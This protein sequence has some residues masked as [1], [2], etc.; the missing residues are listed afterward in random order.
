M[1]RMICSSCGTQNPP[2]AKFCTECASRLAIACAACGTANSPT[3]KYCAECAAPLQGAA[4][5][6]LAATRVAAVVQPQTAT[7][8]LR[9]VS[10]LFADLV[11]F[12]ALAEGRDAEETRELLTN[13]FDLSR[14]V[15]GRYGGTIEKFIGDA[16]MAVWGAPIAREDDA[17]RAVR[18]AIDL[19]AAVGALGPSV[20]ARAGVLTGEAATTVGATNQGM[21]A[22]DLVN[23]ASRLQSVAPSGTV[24]VGEAT[25]RAASRAIVFEEAGEHLLK[26]KASPVP[27]WRA[28]RVVAERGGRNRSETL[29][30]PFVGRDDELRLLKD[31]FHAT[32]REG[33]SRL[34]SVIGPA[35]IG[36][37]RLA[38]EFLKYVD[39][40]VESV[41][42]HDGRS[43]AYGEGIAFWALGEMIRGRAKLH[44]SDDEPTTRSGIAAML[45]EHVPDEA[46]RAW[47]EPALLS[48]LGIGSG[49]GSSQQLFGAWRTFFERLAASG[50]V[51]MIFEDLHH[52]DPGL[53]DFIDHLLDWS[54]NLPILMVTLA[55]PELLERRPDWGAGKRSF[56]SIYLEPLPVPAMRR[57][58]AGLVPGLPAAA[59]D[60]IVKRADGIPLYA[61]ETVR[62]LLAQSRLVLEDGVY[63]P[64]D[65]LTDLAVPDT[66]TALI[67]ARLDELDAPDRA[68]VADAAVLG[69]S[70]T[71]AG[72]AAVSGLDPAAIELRLRAFVRRELLV[73]Q[74]DPRSPER[75]QYAF[76]QALIREVA[77]NTLAKRDRKVRHLAAARYL[78]SLGSD[79]LAGVLANHYLA[80]QGY[81][82][83]GPEADALAAQARVALRGAADRAA[84]LGA[85]TQAI[86]FLEHAI[87]VSP[88]PADR[89]ELHERALASANRGLVNEI[90]QRHALGALEARRELGDRAGIAA[91]TAAWAG[92]IAGFGAGGGRSL[93]ILLPAWEEFADLEAT[94]A[95]VALMQEIARGYVGRKDDPA[96][97]V[98]VER[99]LPVAERLDLL[100]ETT[101]ALA[102]LSSV[103]FRLDRPRE[104]IILLRGAHELA[105]ANDLEEVHR[106]T[107]TILT[108]R[109]QFVDP[110]AGL[111]M[112]REG[113]EIASRLG[114]VAYGFLMVGNA[115]SCA[116]RVGEWAWA[117][118]LL[119]EW[120]TNEITGEFYL[121][122]YADRAVLAALR[123]ADP[124]GDLAEAERLLPGMTDPQYT[125]YC[126]WARAW[127]AFGA[128]RLAD[129]QREA[130]AAGRTT[131]YFVPITMP[132]AAR[133]ALWSGDVVEA[134]AIV[135]ETELSPIRGD[136]VALDLVT[137]RAGIAALEGRRAEAIAAYRDALRGWRALGLAFDEAMAVVD[138]TLLLAPT[139]RE[140]AE[141]P[142]AVES[143]RQTLT[144]LGAWPFLARLDAAGGDL[145][146]GLGAGVVRVAG[147][148]AETT[149]V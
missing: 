58:L 22:G 40:L 74:A 102:R 71:L 49:A 104:G 144:R 107:R 139:E 15:I 63:R 105:V 119:D 44:E 86:T 113:L 36:K 135:A 9:L 116:I 111:A 60:A 94:P 12:T 121:E 138:M 129:A 100:A 10:V 80:A 120:L 145:A 93:E 118:S 131:N 125:S 78:E 42:W 6:A 37:S 56:T 45:R 41:W 140:M 92:T 39:G 62:M 51:V 25:M 2:G 89:V 106:S 26:G 70:F 52:A 18:A 3:A 83:D 32:G 99:L 142:A 53:L 47:I 28:I 90:A 81:A 68:L 11:G 38:W 30:A 148:G 117:L 16:V 149:P 1:A 124:S 109:E 134:K 108:F 128:G 5:A 33:R 91:A 103:L 64:V 24:L 57:L 133:A 76:V 87:E 4:P 55:R 29:E 82:S 114:S 123:G 136:A 130:L 115:V 79:E 126:H 19:V 61:V 59:R 65:D 17:E 146:G 95:G 137:L 112:A 43:P 48:L 132:L 23:T 122:L 35:G 66:L 97:I 54:R 67:S 72:V 84:A 46:E 85:H 77:Y 96:A 73:Q 110:A 147:S 75:G 50:Q 98:W 20:H 69:Q 101:R 141:A 88:D 7:A 127:A 13:Y 34:V 27:A 143:A 8:E 31:L 21:V 14:D